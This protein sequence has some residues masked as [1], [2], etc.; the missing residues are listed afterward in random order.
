[1]S[2]FS[3]EWFACIEVPDRFAPLGLSGTEASAAITQIVTGP[4]GSSE[5]STLQV[6]VVLLPPEPGALHSGAY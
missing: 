2:H 4:S 1:V 6:N 5:A 3:S